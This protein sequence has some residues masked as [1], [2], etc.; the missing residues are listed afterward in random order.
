MTTGIGHYWSAL[1]RVARGNPGG[2]GLLR[3]SYDHLKR[4]ERERI[5]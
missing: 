3:S 2:K 4:R 5:G 1:R